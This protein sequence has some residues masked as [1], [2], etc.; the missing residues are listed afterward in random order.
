[1]AEKLT[2]GTTDFSIDDAWKNLAYAIV[3][4]AVL[5]YKKA[6]RT[7]CRQAKQRGQI[8][9]MTIWKIERIESFFRGHWME[10][11]AGDVVSGE[12]I[13]KRIREEV[14]SDGV[15]DD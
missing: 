2:S 4:Q 11:L 15:E 5:D 8:M 12:K 7:A 10:Q 1:M 3:E 13:I 14:F 9:P 6:L